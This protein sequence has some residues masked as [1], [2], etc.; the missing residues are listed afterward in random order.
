MPHPTTPD[1]PNRPGLEWEKRFWAQGLAFVA[2]MDEAGRGALAGPVVVG[3]VILP[4]SIDGEPALA[5]VRDSK[6]MTP[7]QRAFWAAKVQKTAHS[8]AV[9]L[10][11]AAEIDALGIAAAIQ[12]AAARALSGLHC[13]P[14]ALLCDYGLR[15]PQAALPRESLVKGDARSLSIAAASVLAKVY[16]D[17]LMSQLAI[18]YPGY[19]LEQHKGYGT[20]AHRQALAHL[21][22]SPIHRRSFS[23]K[24]P[25]ESGLA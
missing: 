19:G 16:R 25:P 22:P 7:R 24:R 15:V 2:G 1:L 6:Q 14:Q 5:G 11:S 20:Q 12:Q 17:R 18:R 21:G 13:A 3:A 9:G 8:W 4:P 23:W 10:A